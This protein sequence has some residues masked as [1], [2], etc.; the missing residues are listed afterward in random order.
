[1]KEY[2]TALDLIKHLTSKGIII[3]N[4]DY[5]LDKLKKYS[6]YSIINSYKDVFKDSEN[7]YYQNVSFEEIYTLY[8]FDKNLRIIFL[9]YILEI[10]LIIKSL[11]A[12]LL[13]S[14]YGITDY[15]VEDTFDN[16]VDRTIITE[17]LNKINEEIDKQKEKHEAIA[18]YINTYG[19]IPPFVLVKILTLGEI[20]RLYVMLKQED[21]Q[22]ISKEFKISDKVLKQIL[23]NLTL[24]R[25][26]SAHLER[27]FSFHSKFK[28]SFQYIDDSYPKTTSTNIYMIITAMKK[29]LD[30]DKGKELDNLINL[31]IESLKNTIKSIDYKKILKIMGFP[32]E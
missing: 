2:K 32:D 23:K 8:E 15:L 29:I 16:L 17:N 27:L 13:S 31:E 19:F 28:I 5:A 25:N 26:N 30:I 11:I 20:S 21:R 9:K 22:K 12:E 18:H 24:V 14:K 3:E 7:N 1:M 6:Y 4:E 10:E